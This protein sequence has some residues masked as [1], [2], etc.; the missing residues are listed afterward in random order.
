M[1][2]VAADAEKIPTELR[3]AVCM[4]VLPHTC[5]LVLSDHNRLV[6]LTPGGAR[7]LRGNS[8]GAVRAHPRACSRN[9]GTRSKKFLRERR[10]A[11]FA[12]CKACVVSWQRS[13]SCTVHHKEEERG[14]RT[15]LGLVLRFLFFTFFVFILRGMGKNIA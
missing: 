4:Y 12:V 10:C 6:A 5:A 8:S 11:G 2:R 9:C 7:A 15:V 1:H 3:N 14:R 13:Y